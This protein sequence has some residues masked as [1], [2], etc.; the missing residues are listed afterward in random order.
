MFTPLANASDVMAP[1]TGHPLV[2]DLHLHVHVLAVSANICS[3]PPP[4]APTVI[5]MGIQDH[6][7]EVIHQLVS[8]N[9]NLLIA[10]HQVNLILD[11]LLDPSVVLQP[12]FL[13]HVLLNLNFLHVHQF[14]HHLNNDNQ[15]A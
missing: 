8:R 2:P 10:S 3:I 6:H 1:H 7:L 4:F 9:H 11:H 15:T 12:T 5:L 14:V 13:L